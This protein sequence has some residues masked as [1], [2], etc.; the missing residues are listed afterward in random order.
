MA[1][2]PLALDHPVRSGFTAETAGQTTKYTKHTKNER[3]TGGIL[4]T[5]PGRTSAL[6]NPRHFVCFVYFVVTTV[7]SGKAQGHPQANC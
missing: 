4:F 7:H 5:C 2:T 1:T 3:L 6:P